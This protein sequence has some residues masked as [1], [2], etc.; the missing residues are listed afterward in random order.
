MKIVYFIGIWLLTIT[1]VK[2]TLEISHYSRS[3]RYSKIELSFK[4]LSKI[5]KQIE[6]Y[7]YENKLDSVGRD[8]FYFQIRIKIAIENAYCHLFLKSII[9]HLKMK[10]MITYI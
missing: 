1:V 8:F 5:V 9:F 4:K 10:I 3:N 7:H 6:Y 2:A